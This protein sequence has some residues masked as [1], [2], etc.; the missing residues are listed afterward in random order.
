MIGMFFSLF[1]GILVF[2]RV[3]FGCLLAIRFVLDPLCPAF[4][5]LWTPSPG[6]NVPIYTTK[7]YFSRG[8]LVS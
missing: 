5:S 3:G 4:G 8:G 1:V 2:V 6:R 7:P